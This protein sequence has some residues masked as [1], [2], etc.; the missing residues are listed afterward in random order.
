MSEAKTLRASRRGGRGEGKWGR[1]SEFP[2]HF[3]SG[4]LLQPHV[5]LTSMHLCLLFPFF[6]SPQP[7]PPPP[8][9]KSHVHAAII[10]VCH[11]P[12]IS[13]CLSVNES[14]SVLFWYEILCLEGQPGAT[15]VFP[16]RLQRLAHPLP[17]RIFSLVSCLC[18]CLA[19]KS[20]VLWRQI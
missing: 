12:S 14:V 1:Q 5:L 10:A 19:A 13:T 9:D 4:C 17:R 20:T 11:S 18:V 2:C 15:V 6:S 7:I 3:L 8:P 16:S